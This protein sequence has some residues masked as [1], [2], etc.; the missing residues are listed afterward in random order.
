MSD[1]E[2]AIRQL[3][4]FWMSSTKA[5]DLPA[6][7][8]L[9]TDDVLF[10]TQGRE[11]FG[12]EEYRSASESMKGVELN[13]RATIEEL[14]VSGDWAWLRNRIDLT[15]TTSDGAAVNRSGYTLTIVRKGGD[16]RWR[17]HRD[18]NFVN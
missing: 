1:D 16:G 7:L 14:Q 11:P 8:D 6:V 5:G 17:L 15:V 10:M 13:G 18:A 2:T 3:V 9:M 4:Q 12:K